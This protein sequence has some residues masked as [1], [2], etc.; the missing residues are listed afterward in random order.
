[1]TVQIVL[2]GTLAPLGGERKPLAGRQDGATRGEPAV[3]RTGPLP[4]CFEISIL[5]FTPKIA[6]IS[7][8]RIRWSII[9][10]RPGEWPADHPAGRFHLRQEV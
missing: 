8:R 2:G 5:T 4:Y 6:T 1:M 3:E 7:S 9:L 10:T